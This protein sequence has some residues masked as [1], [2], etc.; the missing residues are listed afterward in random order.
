MC[1]ATRER[2]PRDEM[3][4]LVCDPE[5]VIHVDR[6]LKAPGR[7][8]HLVYSRAALEDAV[9]RRAFGRAFKCAVQAP[10][11]ESLVDAVVQA[12]E[13]RVANLMALGRRSGQAIS[14]TDV[15]NRSAAYLRL[16]IVATDAAPASAEKLHRLGRRVG[17]P[18][19]THGDR[20][21]LGAAQG[22]EERVAVGITD[23]LLA[24]RLE[25]EL[26]WR[27]AVLGAT[28]D[29]ANEAASTPQGG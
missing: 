13:A 9:R 2:L 26:R 12:I 22:K 23:P 24:A 8:A 25:R 17:C 6:Y 7:G 28:E 14:G 29:S 4:R 15:L 19:W 16:L 10:T 27:A 21:A 20:G 1:I 11:V 18:V 5:G 3:I